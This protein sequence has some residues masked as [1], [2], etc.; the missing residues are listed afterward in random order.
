MKKNQPRGIQKKE[1]LPF[2]V[3]THEK[4]NNHEPEGWERLAALTLDVSMALTAGKQLNDCLGRCAE[5]LVQH[6]QV[7][8]ARIWTLNQKEEVLE[9]RASAGLYTHLNGF[10]SRIPLGKYK[11]GLI[12]Q[13]RQTHLTNDLI[14]DPR[15]HD[16]EW[17]IREGMVAFAGYPLIVAD[18]VV[19]VMAVFSR[20]ALSDATIQAMAQ[21]SNAL[22]LGI[23]HR[24]KD[25]ELERFQRQNK[26]IFQ[27]AGEGIYGVDPEGR[28]TFINP[29]AEHMIGWK[30]HEIMGKKMHDILHHTRPNGKPYPSDQCPIYAALKDGQAHHMASEL[31]WRKKG[32]AF[33][34]EYLATPMWDDGSLVGAVVTFSDVTERKQTEVK[35]KDQQAQLRAL[36]AEVARIA[37]RERQRIAEGLHDDIGQTLATLKLKLGNQK[38]FPPE[39]VSAD[40]LK[41]AINLVDQAIQTSRTLTFELGSP[42]LYQLGLLAALKS[43]G[44][45]FQSRHP[46][47]QV[48]VTVT[49]QPMYVE[50]ETAIVLFRVVRELLINIEKHA[51]PT[52]VSVTAEKDKGH[53]HIIVKDNGRGFPATQAMQGAPSMGGFGLFSIIEQVKSIGGHVEVESTPGQGT[54][55]VVQ[56]PLLMEETR[57]FL[58]ERNGRKAHS[59][60]PRES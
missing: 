27:A 58:K 6:L 59:G 37:E 50:D 16:Q 39:T 52:Q 38:E 48:R 49:E 46:E 30:A 55:T 26:L 19:G 22:A 24:E 53:L 21:V 33:P 28:L 12:A 60:S 15:V 2:S 4:V 18:R 44:E 10:H 41:E 8:F 9:L 23:A 36:A 20:A 34:V 31:F 29:A 11:I 35:L 5:A 17:A 7:S 57:N 47:L 56:A 51:K 45:H 3:D 14:G 25:E 42:I 54:R 1:Q 32:K 13:E 40:R 43:L